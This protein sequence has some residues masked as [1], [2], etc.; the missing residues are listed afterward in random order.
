VLTDDYS[1]TP[2]YDDALADPEAY[3]LPSDFFGADDDDEEEGEP[4]PPPPGD[5]ATAH[6]AAYRLRK[7]RCEHLARLTRGL[8]RIHRHLD[9][10]EGSTRMGFSEEWCHHRHLW[11]EEDELRAWAEAT[12][13]APTEGSPVY[14]AKGYPSC[15][16]PWW[17]WPPMMG[18]DSPYLFIHRIRRANAEV[19]EQIA[20]SGGLDDDCGYIWRPTPSPLQGHP[21]RGRGF[22][23]WLRRIFMP[24]SQREAAEK[25]ERKAKKTTQRREQRAK[26]QGKGATGGRSIRPVTVDGAFAFVPLTKGFVARLNAADA[27]L[28]EGFNWC[29]TVANGGRYVYAMRTATA[30][31]G[32]ARNILMH[33]LEGLSGPVEVI[34]PTAATAPVPLAA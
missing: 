18:G 28:V 9:G 26:V 2:L 32:K 4:L 15:S 34:P 1:A 19:S 6:I 13:Y 21:H 23:E 16:L 11:A 10:F 22:D 29:V 27:H 31:N 24:P 14:P 8:L 12:P 7:E 33:R 20:A 30:A 25:A 17:G 5:P 3:G